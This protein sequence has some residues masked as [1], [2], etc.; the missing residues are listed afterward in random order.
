MLLLIWFL[1]VSIFYIA[2]LILC[3]TVPALYNEYED[4]VDSYAERAL[5]EIVKQKEVAQRHILKHYKTAL[6]AFG[7]N[8]AALQLLLILELQK[9]AMCMRNIIC[10]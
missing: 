7:R 10:G 5:K 1:S 8:Y 2:G 9:K 6:S 3:L 4:H